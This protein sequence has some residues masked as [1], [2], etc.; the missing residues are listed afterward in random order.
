M[1]EGRSPKQGRSPKTEP[2]WAR[3]RSIL[4]SGGNPAKAGTTRLFA[5]A[6]CRGPPMAGPAIVPGALPPQCAVCSSTCSK[7]M[8]LLTQ[9]LVTVFQTGATR[10][11]CYIAKSI[12][13][14]KIFKLPV[15]SV[16]QYL[17]LCQRVVQSPQCSLWSIILDNLLGNCRSARGSRLLP[18]NCSFTDPPRKSPRGRRSRP[19][20]RGATECQ[21]WNQRI[22]LA[23]VLWFRLRRAERSAR[24]SAPVTQRSATATELMAATSMSGIS[25]GPAATSAQ[26]RFS[27]EQARLLLYPHWHLTHIRLPIASSQSRCGS[28]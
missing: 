26:Q 21:A 13:F 15:C 27:M 3:A 22:Y 11:D 10:M 18:S 12:I 17:L 28:T 2:G 4:E 24:Y 20:Q 14:A 8:P 23:A 19:F 5:R 1:S 7:L 25:L 6:D 16:C 9:L